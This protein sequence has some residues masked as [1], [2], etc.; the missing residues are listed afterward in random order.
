[1]L[2][3]VANSGGFPLTAVLEGFHRYFLLFISS[4]NL[5][6]SVDKE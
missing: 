5:T 6:H 1:M 4:A 2:E 3:E